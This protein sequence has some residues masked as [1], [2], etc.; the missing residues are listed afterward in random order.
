VG[1]GVGMGGRG[2]MEKKIPKI[3]LNGYVPILI[4]GLFCMLLNCV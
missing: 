3:R 4:N 1:E 2:G